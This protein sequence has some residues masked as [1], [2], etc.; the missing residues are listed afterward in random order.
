MSHTKNLAVIVTF[1][2]AAGYV[3][4]W[5]RA[6]YAESDYRGSKLTKEEQRT[7]DLAYKFQDCV[8]AKLST[9]PEEERIAD[10]ENLIGQGMIGNDATKSEKENLYDWAEGKC[11]S[12]LNIDKP[13]LDIKMDAIYEKTGKKL[14]L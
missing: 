12:D 1:A 9:V 11:V 6:P 7:V 2:F 14:S 13:G 10:V 3:V 5:V 4:D 8:T